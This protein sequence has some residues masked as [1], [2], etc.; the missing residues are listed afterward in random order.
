MP[1]HSAP[2]DSSS[3]V[4]LQAVG[5]ESRTHLLANRQE[6]GGSKQPASEGGCKGSSSEAVGH[7]PVLSGLTRQVWK[8]IDPL[9]QSHVQY[10]INNE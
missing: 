2:L 3:L 6:T 7:C 5:G 4:A 8:M 9:L 10:M 1:A